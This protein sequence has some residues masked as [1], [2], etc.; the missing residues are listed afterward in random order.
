MADEIRVTREGQGAAAA[1]ARTPADPKAARA[2]IE[3]TRTRMSETIDEIEDTLV[4]QKASIQDRM[5]ILARVRERPLPS[6]GAA[7][8]AGLIL[9]L[10]TGG[11]D[12]DNGGERYVL[13][14]A[15]DIDLEDEDEDDEGREDREDR[16]DDNHWRRRAET[17]ESRARRL[18]DVAR[19]QEA[20]LHDLNEE[21]GRTRARSFEHG[22]GRLRSA[23]GGVRDGIFGGLTGFLSQLF[24]DM[25]GSGSARRYR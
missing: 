2:E 19:D 12:E 18:R 15:D 23:V 4:R 8:G 5:D 11:G 9:G 24:E 1:Q 14:D 3:N 6:A 20:E 21:R 25:T 10:L 13:V 7:L 17:W 22:S 16:E